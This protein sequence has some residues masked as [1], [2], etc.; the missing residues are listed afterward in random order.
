MTTDPF[1]PTSTIQRDRWERPLI[2]PPGQTTPVAYLR[3]SSVPNQLNDDF[4]IS[5]WKMHS[6]TLGLGKRRDLWQHAATL[7]RD[8]KHKLQEIVD[9]AMEMV[10][11]DTQANLGSAIHAYLQTGMDRPDDLPEIHACAVGIRTAMTA[12]GLTMIDGTAEMFVINDTIQAAG[13]WDGLVRNAEG[14][15]MVFDIKT[16]SQIANVPAYKAQAWCIQMAIYANANR[17]ADNRPLPELE[18]RKGVVAF[19]DRG[20]GECR[21]LTTNLEWGWE[22]AQLARR[23]YDIKKTKTQ[24]LAVDAPV[25]DAI[26]TAITKVQAR[27]GF[28]DGI[29]ARIQQDQRLLKKLA[30][31]TP[32][33]VDAPLVEVTGPPGL[34]APVND[35]KVTVPTQAPTPDTPT[36]PVDAPGSVEGPSPQPGWLTKRDVTTIRV[37]AIKDAG[38]IDQLA[39]QWP[40]GVPGLR[41][42]HQHTDDDLDAI[43]EACV[44]VERAHMMPFPP[45][46]GNQNPDPTLMPLAARPAPR[47]TFDEGPPITIEQIEHVATALK[48]LNKTKVAWIAAR[49]SES[50]K[51]GV[52]LNVRANPTTRR[53]EI[54]AAL[55]ALSHF[56]TEPYGDQI[57]RAILAEA[58]DNDTLIPLRTVGRIIGALSINEAQRVAAMGHNLPEITFD[59]NGNVVLTVT[60]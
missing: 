6:L 51:A 8:D 37:Q 22:Q 42:T 5:R 20:T 4:A 19:V 11:E 7:T 16:S 3:P 15:V 27:P 18:K 21:L 47:P 2:T 52:P 34:V 38:H 54:A 43:A 1:A 58:T 23:A 33:A 26:E 46:E 39:D 57:V 28:V 29:Q 53:Y 9:A 36:P 10:A 45:L 56:A 12:A 31:S 41:T 25:V 40:T 48:T 55:I 14:D 32:G 24:L 50:H 13:S 35:T 49:S 17:F 59:N 30:H 44:E 60:S